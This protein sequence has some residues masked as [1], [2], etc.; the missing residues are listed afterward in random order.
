MIDESVATIITFA[1]GQHAVP[2]DVTR[3]RYTW[4]TT[5]AELAA[6]YTGNTERLR[7]ALNAMHDGGVL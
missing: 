2:F 1:G 5:V 4:A 7:Q 6:A 3:G